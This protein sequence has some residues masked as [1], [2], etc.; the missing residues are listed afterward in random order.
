MTGPTIFAGRYE[1]LRS[2]GRGAQGEVYA[3]KDLYEQ[4]EAALKLLAPTHPGMQWVEA[5]VLRNLEDH[6]ILPIRNADVHMGQPYLVT[7]LARHGS[8]E[9]RIEATGGT[10]IDVDTA[11]AWTRQACHGLNRA[12]AARLVHNDVK[13]GNL[14]INDR[15][16]CVVA[17]FGYAGLI[18]AGTGLAFAHGASAET[19]APEVAAVWGTPAHAAS[20]ASDIFSLGAS[21]WWMLTGHAPIDLSGATDAA[22][23][24]AIAASAS[25]PRLRDVAPH[26][27][28]RVGDC[29][30]KAMAAAAGDRFEKA[31]DLAAALGRRL[32]VTRRWERTDEHAGH[33]GCWRGM[34]TTSAR[35]LLVCAEPGS[36]RKV[37]IRATYQPSGRTHS[38]GCRT[39]TLASWIA[40]V[41]AVIASLS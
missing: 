34:P 30:D 33:L 4:S 10:G 37:A 35:P 6:H 13:P 8:I 1:L 19:V 5:T 16:E 31:T 20:V 14:F 2:L 27:P 29:V 23:R 21:A 36:G 11:V 38:A 3:V 7:A 26:V 17:D 22:A 32:P 28:K 39:T 18:D 9:K 24:M 15:D 41:R 40:G 12:H 25:R